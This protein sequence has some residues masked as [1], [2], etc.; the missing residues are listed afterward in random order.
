MLV[1]VR[2]ALVVVI[3]LGV[4][5]VVGGFMYDILFAG[6]PYQDPPPDLQARYKADQET[7]ASI[8][9]VGFYIIVPGS[10]LLAASLFFKVKRK[11]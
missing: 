8:M 11:P 2:I 7:A 4:V 10:F 3:S 5:T 9:T 6:I 1:A